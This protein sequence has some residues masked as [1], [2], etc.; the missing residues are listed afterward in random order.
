MHNSPPQIITTTYEQKVSLQDF[1]G[2]NSEHGAHLRR[3]DQFFSHVHIKNELKKETDRHNL[4][5]VG[6]RGLMLMDSLWS[7]QQTKPQLPLTFSQ[8][9]KDLGSSQGSVG[10]PLAILANQGDASLETVL[11]KDEPKKCKACGSI[12]MPSYPKVPRDTA[13]GQRTSDNQWVTAGLSSHQIIRPNLLEGTMLTG[14]LSLDENDEAAGASDAGEQVSA[15]GKLRRRSRKGESRVE[16]SHGPYARGQELLA[17]RRNSR[18]RSSLEDAT[19]SRS[20][21]GVTFGT[22][23]FIPTGTSSRSYRDSARIQLPI[24]SA[25]KSGSKSR[26]TEQHGMMN[27]ST[28]Q[29]VER[30]PQHA[31]ATPQHFDAPSQVSQVST[32]LAPYIKPYSLRYPSPEA[33]PVEQVDGKHIY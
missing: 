1:R 31:V 19:G 21:R 9:S 20:K 27:V 11:Y 2:R 23:S 13:E 26:L 24:K 33:T 7:K 5:N 8:S 32:G 29:E 16:V 14:S 28:A 3:Q 6:K 15:F 10:I 30:S 12:L 4:D 25:L 17:Q 22:D 18:T